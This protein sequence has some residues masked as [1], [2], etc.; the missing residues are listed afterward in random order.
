ALVAARRISDWHGPVLAQETLTSFI[1]EGHLMRHVRRMRK[2][3]GDRRT[4]L[5]HALARHCGGAVSP[6]PGEAGLHLAAR[7]TAPHR[8]NVMVARAA[9]QG[10][11]LQALQS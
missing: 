5:L 3:Y 8:A 7:L 6:I 1:A 2:V 10:V 9:E 11:K 4:A